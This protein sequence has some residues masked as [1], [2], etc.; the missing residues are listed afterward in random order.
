MRLKRRELTAGIAAIGA[1]LTLFIAALFLASLAFNLG[2]VSVRCGP[3]DVSLGPGALELS[4]TDPPQNGLT[5]GVFHRYEY[6][7]WVPLLLIGVP[8][9]FLLLRVLRRPRG[10][11]ECK[12][13]GYDMKGA[14]AAI[15]PECG[16]AV[17]DPAAGSTNSA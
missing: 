14:R 17:R 15:C 7:F 16:A 8:T 12:T 9:A 2:G 3:Y 6:P 1:A 11:N 5:M 10:P 13:C 4:H